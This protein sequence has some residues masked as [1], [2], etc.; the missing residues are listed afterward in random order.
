MPGK[1]KRQGILPYAVEVTEQFGHTTARAGL[2]LVVETMRALGADKA[3]EKHI[4]LQQR[5]G[6][7]SEVEKVEAL[8][9]LLA[10]GGECFDDI[11]ALAADEGLCRLLGRQMPSP[12][13]L[14]HFLYEFHDE[15]LVERAKKLRPA[16]T[17]AYIPAE[18]ELL[19][20]LSQVNLALVHAVAARGKG[21]RA[22]LD[23]DAT[24]QESH[25][26]EALPHYKGG[27]GYQPACI[28]WA[29]QDLIIGDEYRDGNVPAGMG[30]LPL[31]QKA[32]ESLPNKVKDRFFR[33]DSACY[34]ASVL[35][36]LADPERA[37]TSS[38]IGFTI[39][40][41]MTQELH[42]LCTRVAE[43]EWQMVDERADETVCCAEVEF[44]PGHWSKDAE[45]LRYVAVRIKKRQGL[46]FSSGYDVKYLAVVSNRRELS[47]PE[48]LRWHWQKAGTIEHVHDVTK[49]ELG[50][51]TPPCG[52][53]GANA[54]WYRLALFTYN[55]LSAMKSLALP[56]EFGAA[57]PKKLRFSL[58]T[59][60]GRIV[61]HAGQ[62]VLRIGAVAE[63][64]VQLIASR[65][66]LVAL[67]PAPD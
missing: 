64:L 5:A 39:S 63:R 19:I 53:F 38:R 20:G 3:I 60:A 26:R 67:L 24:I 11:R 58:F 41:D 45:P 16:G 1:A 9:L 7:Y 25:K 42:L 29:E 44:T 36:W 37:G 8:V 55:V 35:K 62:L 52:R 46:L 65:H 21:T 10:A 48:L 34:E 30:N 2:P 51:G 56:P 13:T 49:N 59:L 15:S 14:R 28:Y 6:G 23:H 47:A 32:F 33:A 57:R 12:D 4:Q 43:P 66:R 54:A 22:T 18:S 31:I 50:A 17:V 27:R 61:E 40:A